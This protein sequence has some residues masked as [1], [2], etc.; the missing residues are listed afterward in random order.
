MVAAQTGTLDVHVSTAYAAAQTRVGR[1]CKII[2]IDPDD[3]DVSIISQDM[4]P[5][6]VR[7]ASWIRSN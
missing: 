4:P 3:V 7:C 1:G 2:G 5:T 6:K